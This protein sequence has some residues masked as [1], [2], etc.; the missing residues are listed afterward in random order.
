MIHVEG[1][2]DSIYRIGPVALVKSDCRSRSVLLTT[3]KNKKTTTRA[4]DT[5]LQIDECRGAGIIGIFSAQK[6]TPVL[7]ERLQYLDRVVFIEN[8]HT[9]S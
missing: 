9:R 1:I 5:D 4:L 2:R 3:Q 6:K 7:R 8:Q